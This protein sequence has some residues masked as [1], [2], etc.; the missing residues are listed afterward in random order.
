[1]LKS[2][3]LVALILLFAL[4]VLGVVLITGGRKLPYIQ[5]YEM[6]EYGAAQP[7]MEPHSVVNGLAVYSRGNGRAVLLF[8][9]PHAANHQPMVQSPLADMLVAMGRTVITFDLPGAYRST[10]TP[11]GD[12]QEIVSSADEAL[13]RLEIE[14]SV[15]V[16]GHSMGAFSALAYA[17]ERPERVNRLAL[18]GAMSGFPAVFKYGMPKSAWKISQLEYWRF[19]FLGLR[20]KLGWGNLALHKQ[21]VNSM[22]RASFYDQD[23]FIPLDIDADD[24]SKGIPVREILWGQNMYRNLSYADELDHIHAPTLIMAGKFDPEAPLPCAQELT[25]GIS[26]SELIVFD[27]SGHYPYLEES[28]KFYKVLDGFLNPDSIE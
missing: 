1:M 7:F 8:P 19:V 25:A 6:Q 15:D 2:M 27:K 26:N 13:A 10:R 3:I 20:V 28:T 22:T 17:V 24:Y 5:N 23:Q 12:I 14:G 4:G 16:L 21:L 11:I 18:V 9:Y